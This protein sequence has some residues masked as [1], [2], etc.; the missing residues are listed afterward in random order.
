MF[1]LGA[2]LKKLLGNHQPTQ[3]V[4]GEHISKHAG[5]SSR[6]RN[7]D[8]KRKAR[9]KMRGCRGESIA[10]WRN[11]QRLTGKGRPPCQMM[12]TI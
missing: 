8:A 1:D 11:T 6:P 2:A 12:P 9:L 10:S 4:R 3:P 7:F 5:G